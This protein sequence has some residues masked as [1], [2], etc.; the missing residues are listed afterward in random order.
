M[1]QREIFSDKAQKLWLQPCKAQSIF[2][3]YYVALHFSGIIV[4]HMTPGIA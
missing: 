4:V 1:V 2:V 3:R